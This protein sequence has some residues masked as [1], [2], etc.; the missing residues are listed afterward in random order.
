MRNRFLGI[1][2]S[3]EEN[4]ALLNLAER[5]G[6]NKSLCAR[7]LLRLELIKQGQL[8]IHNPAPE[9]VRV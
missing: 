4:F 5:E 2:L 8:P 9:G 6:I 1:K 7:R 3:D